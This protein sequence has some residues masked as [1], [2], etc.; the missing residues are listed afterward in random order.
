MPTGSHWE[1]GQHPGI[2]AS[3]QGL[4]GAET[5]SKSSIAGRD[6]GICSGAAVPW[7]CHHSPLLW[8]V[9]VAA[10]VGGSW[11]LQPDPQPSFGVGLSFCL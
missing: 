5:P 3:P 7:L 8:G 10:R 11:W 4:C 1:L 9:G 2:G 6:F